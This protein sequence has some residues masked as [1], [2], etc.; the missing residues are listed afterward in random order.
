MRRREL[1]QFGFVLGLMLALL[2]SSSGACLCSHHRGKAAETETPACHGYGT[3]SRDEKTASGDSST[4][5]V[6]TSFSEGECCC[7][8]RSVPKIVA[9]S[10]SVK[11]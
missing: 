1:K 7:V 5:T 4:E 10:E 2:A 11:L 3:E 9:K 8:Q 6:N